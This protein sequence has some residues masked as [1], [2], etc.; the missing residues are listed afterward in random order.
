VQ[1]LKHEGASTAGARD[2]PPSAPS[3][4]GDTLR[5]QH[6][7]AVVRRG[8]ARRRFT[9]SLALVSMRFDSQTFS[10]DNVSFGLGNWACL[11][12]PWLFHESIGATSYAEFCI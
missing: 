4:H 10:D 6:G 2:Q 1:R 9:C 11:F 7:N 3:D 12:T 5:L 8:G